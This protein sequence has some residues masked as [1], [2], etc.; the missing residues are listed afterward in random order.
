[1]FGLVFDIVGIAVVLIVTGYALAMHYLRA[2]RDRLAELHL[3]VQG[4]VVAMQQIQRV[5]DAYFA[6][7]DELRRRRS[8]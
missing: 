1:M 8:S 6:A 3:L 7:R 2:E 4:E 5:H